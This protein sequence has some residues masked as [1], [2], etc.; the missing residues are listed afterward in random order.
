MRAKIYLVFVFSGSCIL[1]VV[2]LWLN[3]TIEWTIDIVNVLLLYYSIILKKT[4]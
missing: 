1:Y 4:M 3:G 2:S